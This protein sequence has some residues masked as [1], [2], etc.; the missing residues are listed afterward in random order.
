MENNAKN[1]RKII[2]A[3]FIP[4]II[5]ILTYGIAGTMNLCKSGRV[6]TL[7]D[8]L[9]CR[10]FGGAIHAFDFE[11]TWWIWGLGLLAVFIAEMVIISDNNSS[12]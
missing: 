12:K 9:K 3:I 6:L 10:S 8:K 2:T 11:K 1:V 4:I 5:G 7:E